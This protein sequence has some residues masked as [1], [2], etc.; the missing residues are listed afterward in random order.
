MNDAAP[1]FEFALNDF[2][3]YVRE[4]MEAQYEKNYKNLTTPTLSVEAGRR[5]IRIV[6]A[7]GGSRSVYGFVDTTNGDI[8]KPAS[9]KAP[10]KHARG[11]IFNP[12]TWTCAGV[13]GIAYM[14]AA[15]TGGANINQDAMART[16]KQGVNASTLGIPKRRDPKRVYTPH[17]CRSQ[18]CEYCMS[19]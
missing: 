6:R 1:T 3:A 12:M 8:L 2:L 13:H 18:P 19:T 16:K 9:W 4:T 17:V 10:A 5:Y 7:D 11:N 14:T 15:I